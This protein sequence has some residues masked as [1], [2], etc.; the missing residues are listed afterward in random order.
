LKDAVADSKLEAWVK[1][2][3]E[4]SK[5]DGIFGET[6]FMGARDNID[7][8]SESMKKYN[9][10]LGEATKLYADIDPETQWKHNY[11]NPL[12]FISNWLSNVTVK[13]FG[14]QTDLF[15]QKD[16]Y[17]EAFKKAYES[18][19]NEVEA[20]VLRINNRGGFFNFFGWQDKFSV[21]K[22]V[23]EE[24]GYELYGKGGILNTEALQAALTTY[25]DEMTEEQKRWVEEAIAATEKYAEAMD[26]LDD[27]V[28]KLFGNLAS[29]IASSMIDSFKDI[30]VAAYGLEGVFSDISESIINNLLQTMLIEEVLNK[31]SESLKAIM[32]DTSLSDEERANALLRIMANMRVDILAFA[33]GKNAFLEAAKEAGLLNMSD[34]S[35]G[36]FGAE[37]WA[38]AIA[39]IDALIASMTDNAGRY[40][41]LSSKKRTLPPSQTFPSSFCIFSA[42]SLPT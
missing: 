14:T 42:M 40:N 24:L 36:D 20:F 10:V 17:I 4:L 1:S 2:V 35:G 23:V 29:D 9:K 18:G 5:S 13:I 22:D 37:E 38:K 28:S 12:G 32:K 19:Y 21:L 26:A 3:D 25:G 15:A 39:E 6:F 16:A 7:A 11:G 41:L 33:Q 31:Y 8:A 34:M 30:G 27:Y